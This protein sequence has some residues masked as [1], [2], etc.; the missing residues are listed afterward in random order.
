[1]NFLKII[2]VA[3]FNALVGWLFVFFYGTDVAFSIVVPQVWTL[4]YAI[5]LRKEKV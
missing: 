2:G 3:C 5:N 1:M 4:A